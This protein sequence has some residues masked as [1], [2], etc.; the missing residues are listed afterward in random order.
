MRPLW[1]EFPDDK[2]TYLNS[3]E[4][5]LGDDVL[6]APVVKE[7]MRNRDF[8]LPAGTAWINW[9]TGERLDGGK[10]HRV[11]VPLD[12]LPIFVRAGAVIPTQDVIQHTGEMSRAAITLNV[13]VGIDPGKTEVAELYQDAGDGYGYRLSEW[14]NIRIEHRQGMLK[15]SRI[16]DFRGQPIRYIEAFGLA[17]EPREIRADGRKLEFRFDA[18]TRRLR[19]EVPENASEI[20]MVR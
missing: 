10:Q 9:W 15:V 11:D 6:V 5:M 3:D 17:A 2:L 14:R 13:P 4:F 16:G 7:G 8:Y 12:R 19:V 20:T 1:F 18:A